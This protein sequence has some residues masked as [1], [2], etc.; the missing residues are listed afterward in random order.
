M[1]KQTLEQITQ[2][3]YDDIVEDVNK[4]LRDNGFKEV[5]VGMVGYSHGLQYGEMGCG[6]TTSINMEKVLLGKRFEKFEESDQDMERVPKYTVVYKG[7]DGTI[8]TDQGVDADGL[9]TLEAIG[10]EIHSKEETSHDV[11]LKGLKTDRSEAGDI[12]QEVLRRFELAKKVQKREEIAK[13]LIPDDIRKKLS[14]VTRTLRQSQAFRDRRA[15]AEADAIDRSVLR[16][17][18]VS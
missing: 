8:Q 3:Y 14:P 12:V 13:R 9:A 17:P 15:A 16:I 4:A 18:P 6:I 5:P 10:L 2:E 1:K 7:F 11:A